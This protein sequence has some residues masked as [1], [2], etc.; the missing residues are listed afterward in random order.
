MAQQNKAVAL[1]PV[2]L[3]ALVEAARQS[4]P[5]DREHFI[6]RVIHDERQ[7]RQQRH[8]RRPPFTTHEEYWAAMKALGLHRM[9]Q[10][11]LVV[12]WMPYGPDGGVVAYASFDINYHVGVLV[13]REH[14][15]RLRRQVV[16]QVLGVP[17]ALAAPTKD[18]A[19]VLHRG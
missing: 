4:A 18:W 9:Y 13:E 5:E 19:E 1:V 11:T 12:A 10:N 15:L 6:E 17:L 16:E 2:E 7:W 14:V 3:A 8:D